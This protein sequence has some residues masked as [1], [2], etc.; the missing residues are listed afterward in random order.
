MMEFVHIPV[1]FSVSAM[2]KFL[3]STV[4]SSNVPKATAKKYFLKLSTTQNK[5]YFPE[6][7]FSLNFEL[8]P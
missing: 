7:H 2:L 1:S 8:P 4:P 6:I 3:L 5:T